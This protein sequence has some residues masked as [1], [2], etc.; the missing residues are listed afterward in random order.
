H[1]VP[2]AFSLGE[3]SAVT[4][5]IELDSLLE[6]QPDQVQA[7]QTLAMIQCVGSRTPDNPNC[8]RI[9]CQSAIKNAL[10]ALDLNPELR[11]FVLYRDMRTYGFSEDYYAE[12]RRR[13]VIF[14][15]YETDTP[16]EVTPDGDQVQVVFEDPILGRKLSIEADCLALSTGMAVNEEATED[17]AM[18][19]HLNRTLDGCFL[20][21][22]VKLRPTDLSVP[23]FFVAGSVH[24]PKNI[25]EC[26]AQSQA[27]ASRVLAMLSKDTINLGAT[28]AR[29][30]PE[31]CATCLAC[32]RACPYGVPF[33][34][35]D[36]YSEIDPA[37]CHG[38]GVCAA[39]CPAKAIE[40][41]RFEDAPIMAR[42]EGLLE[43]SA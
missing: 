6:D 27:A 2:R 17:L 25:K 20:E 43:R 11:V 38:C 37:K 21:E 7:W 35:E 3:H 23:G 26:I 5:Q 34:N 1:N 15:R 16:P 41:T 31:K 40:L 36:R 18:I 8:S 28:V 19:F 32:V 22:H 10:R 30:D 24:A 9:C 12:A 14:V 13:G 39:E 4:T 42:L 33:I 29:V